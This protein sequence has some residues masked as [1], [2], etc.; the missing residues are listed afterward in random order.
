MRKLT[1]QQKRIRACDRILRRAYK[2]LNEKKY[3][4]SSDNLQERINYFEEGK[5]RIEISL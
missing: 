4:G 5:D 2:M 1:F 3:Q